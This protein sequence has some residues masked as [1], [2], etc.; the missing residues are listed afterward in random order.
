MIDYKGYI[1]NYPK[2]HSHIT[3]KEI[4]EDLLVEI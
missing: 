1:I 3:D 4:E 2:V